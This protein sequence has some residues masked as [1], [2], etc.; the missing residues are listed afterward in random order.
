MNI[1]VC[2]KQ[3]PDPEMPSSRLSV[4]EATRKVGV[5]ANAEMVIS[6]FDEN[7]VE[8]A[9]QLKE[10]FG[11]RVVAL[12][13]GNESCRQALRRALAMGADEA[14]LL[15]DPAFLGGDSYS[16]AY[17]LAQAVRRIGSFDLVLCGREAA[18][19]DAGQVPIGIAEFLGL[20]ALTPIGSIEVA[21]GRLLLRRVTD[22][23]YDVCELT[24]PAVLGISNESN[25][26]RYPPLKG[27]IEASKKPFTTWAAADI[28][29]DTSKV[30]PAMAKTRL[31]ALSVPMMER[32]CEFVEG[33]S[34]EEI[35]E[36]LV[37]RLRAER[38][39]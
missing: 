28:G 32:E 5:P 17:T 7:A 18:D 16:N 33:D 15:S 23:G 25:T 21:D 22:D 3:V 10:A 35:A 39:L 11:G 27:I 8:A 36:K 30:G 26:P 4:D 29:A 1:V 12:S 14:V 9:L 37:Q 19:W 20:P 24:P 6:P 38:A 13:M 34:F 2:I 31:A